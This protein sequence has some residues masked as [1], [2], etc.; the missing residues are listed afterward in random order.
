MYA[1]TRQDAEASN[2]AVT[3][4]VLVE[5]LDAYVLFDTGSTHSFV[6]PRLASKLGVEPRKMEIP[7]VV[8]SPLG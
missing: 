6:S 3:G 4:T 1:I 7:L 8:S 5:T 2:T